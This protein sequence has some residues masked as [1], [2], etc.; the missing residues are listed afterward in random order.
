MKKKVLATLVAFIAILAQA[1]AGPVS[2][3]QAKEFATNF[4]IDQGVALQ[5]ELSVIEGPVRA[6]DM[7][8]AAPCYYVFNNGQ[9]GGFV[10]ISGDN[11]TQMVLG[12]STKG[13]FNFNEE[14]PATMLLKQYASELDIL[15]RMNVTAP[16][17]ETLSGMSHLQTP[18]HEAIQPLITCEW[19]QSA[20]YNA[21]CPVYNTKT[22]LS[23][24]VTVA[25]A[26]LVYYYRDRMSATLQKAIPGYTTKTLKIKVNGVASGTKLN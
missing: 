10:I 5:G 19:N 18:T 8:D 25:M 1:V 6:A 15:D 13:H 4:L 14:N 17:D 20:P 9:D 7:R 16:I 24:C 3:E 23:G 2:K 22:T 11:R 12:F 26:Q 21:S